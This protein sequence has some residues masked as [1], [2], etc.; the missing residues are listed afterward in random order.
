MPHIHVSGQSTV[1]TVVALTRSTSSV[2]LSAS[3]LGRPPV[4]HTPSSTTQRTSRWSG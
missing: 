2:S 1:T 4:P 3:V